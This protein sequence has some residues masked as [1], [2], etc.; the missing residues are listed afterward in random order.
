MSTSVTS[1]SVASSSMPESADATPEPSIYTSIFWWSFTANI[2]LVAGN[3]LTFRFAELVN[4][5]GGTQQLA[6]TIVSVGTIGALVGRLFMGQFLDRYGVRPVWATVSVCYTVGIA[7]MILVPQLGFTMYAGRILFAFGLGGMFACSMTHIQDQVPAYRRTEVIATL[8]S[9]GFIGMMLGSQLG[10]LV[11]GFTAD[12]FI[13]YWTLFGL[14]GSFGVVYLC[15]V[16]WLTRNDCHHSEHPQVS[17]LPL[18]FRYWPG[19]VM[20]VGM[21]MGMAFVS[22]TVF[23]ARYATSLGL[24]GVGTY[25]TAYA[26]T[27]FCVRI[28]TRNM[29][30]KYGRHRM[31]VLA[32]VGHIA[33]LCSLCFVTLEWQFIIPAACTGF[34]HALLFPC[35]VSLGTE[36]FPKQYRGTATTLVLC[37]IDVGGVISAPIL[38]SVIDHIG[39]HTMFLLA[40]GVIAVVDVIYLVA[41]FR[42][43][44]PETLPN[45]RPAVMV[46]PQSPATAQPLPTQTLSETSHDAGKAPQRRGN[47][48]DVTCCR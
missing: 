38:G 15:I 45:A 25:F 43:V 41:T 23:L 26:I 42:M 21:A 32:M 6:G 14:S 39:F 31:I 16:L 29:S 22:T 8:G 34:A 37:T 9:S 12:S 40:A 28:L 2:L 44:D 35:V 20:L 24:R 5:L 18:L 46:Q 19:S 47:P 30:R 33:G 13:R 1:E 27:A 7:L 3:A 11:L 36:P 48:S 17:A 4:L 10:D